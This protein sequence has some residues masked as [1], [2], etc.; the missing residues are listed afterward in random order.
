MEMVSTAKMKKFQD[1]LGKSKIFDLKL[2][3][4][5][6]NL[7]AVKG[8]EYVDPLLY[9]SSWPSRILIFEI[10]G[11]R[12]LCGSFNSNIIKNTARLKEEL[13]LEGKESFIYS[14]GKKGMNYYAF[15]K[16]NCYKAI[17]NLDDSLSFNDAANFGEELINLFLENE[18]HEIYIS[19]SKVLSQSSQ[20]PKVIKLL[21]VSPLVNDDV[22]IELSSASSSDYWFEPSP[23]RVFSHLL[24]LFIKVKIYKCFL[25]TSYSEFFARRVAMKNATDASNEMIRDLTVAYNR[26]RQAKIT[27]EI[28]EIIGGAAGLE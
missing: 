20:K 25:E 15:T 8:S 27:N 23:D 14:I 18:F 11:N 4:I 13:F 7:F 2:T 28:S 24:P 22:D 6:N 12:G 16:Q 26:A 19:Y 17:P 21:P 9:E 1:R 3:G 10:V 5:L